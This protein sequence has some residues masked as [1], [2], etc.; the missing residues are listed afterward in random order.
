MK[1]TYETAKV[2]YDLLKSTRGPIVNEVFVSIRDEYYSISK[3]A[4]NG[5]SFTIEKDFIKTN[6]KYSEI[7][8]IV[9][10]LT[11][12][13]EKSNKNMALIKDLMSKGL[14]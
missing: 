14:I 9:K 7:N 13:T 8:N 6:D 4:T 11:I 10:E 12:Q 1:K 5:Y 3:F 2:I